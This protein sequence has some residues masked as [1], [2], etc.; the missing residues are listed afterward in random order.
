MNILFIENCN[1]K[2]QLALSSRLLEY[3]NFFTRLGDNV[4][5]L[6]SSQKSYNI[7][8]T[9]VIGLNSSTYSITG[10]AKFALKSLK[11]LKETINEF[12]I[13]HTFQPNLSSNVPVFL[14]LIKKRHNVRVINDIRSLWIEMGL[15][16]A[17]ISKQKGEII[18][19]LLYRTEKFFFR[20][21]DYHFIIS[22]FHKKHYEKMMNIKIKNSSI[23]PNCLKGFKFKKNKR[24]EN[25]KIIFGY[26]GTLQ[27]MR[28]LERVFKIFK[29]IPGV[30]LHL[31][32]S[33]TPTNLPKNV[34]Y[35][36]FLP[37][38][39]IQ[40]ALNTFDVGLHHFS[41]PGNYWVNLLTSAKNYPRKILEYMAMGLPIMA[42]NR[43]SY[44]R[45]FGDLL[46]YYDMNN[47]KEKII[48]LRDNEK[49]REKKG[50]LAYETFKKNYSLDV[51]GK[52]MRDIY[53]KII[54]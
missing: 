29:E 23:I 34:K 4:T 52:K 49:L 30:E 11:E 48:L 53:K 44:R 5:I 50:K 37:Y 13:I 6:S 12:D 9:H 1:L 33:P 47:L 14:S 8:K 19:K 15:A 31:Y 20:I 7:N 54:S 51:V 24:K 35:K 10:N 27:K 41:N 46:I 25:N 26:I 45:S 39:E 32:G 18:R 36:G 43:I 2:T 28:G 42:T 38:F 3:S 22:S 40:K 16:K 21:A 17:N